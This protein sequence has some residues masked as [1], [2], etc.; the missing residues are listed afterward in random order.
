[1]RIKTAVA[2]CRRL[3]AVKA[4]G[5]PLDYS[6]T[7]RI[8]STYG[9]LTPAFGVPSP[10]P[11]DS[12][13]GVMLIQT[14]ILHDGTASSSRSAVNFVHRYQPA[15]STLAWRHNIGCR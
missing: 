8:D 11:P 6:A 10:A 9:T 13:P 15:R 4:L 3:I 7:L 2:S 5:R 12:Y 14:I 1:M